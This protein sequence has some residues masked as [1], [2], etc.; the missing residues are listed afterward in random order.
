ME[1]ADAV[2]DEIGIMANGDLKCVG[3]SQ[4]LK[5]KFGQGYMLEIHTQEDP[6][7]IERVHRFVMDLV[8][9]TTVDESFGGKFRFALPRGAFSLPFLFR[10]IESN[11]DAL[12]LRDFSLS[13]ASL[14]QIFIS[15]GAPECCHSRLRNRNLRARS[16]QRKI[17]RY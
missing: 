5:S 3:T 7:C 9:N 17:D 4:R 16:N 6:V 13:Q 1:E 14:E 8:A 11:R 12:Q 2:C 10:Q 15:F